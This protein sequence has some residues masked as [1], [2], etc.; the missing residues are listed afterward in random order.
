M[1]KQFLNNYDRARDQYEKLIVSNQ[2]FKQ[3]MEHCFQTEEV[4]VHT[5]RPHLDAW[6][7]L[8]VQRI[9]RYKLLLGEILKNTPDDHSGRSDTVAAVDTI[10]DIAKELD[11]SNARDHMVQV[12]RE[13]ADLIRHEYSSL[14]QPDRLFKKSGLVTVHEEVE[15][16]NMRTSKRQAYLFSDLLVLLDHGNSQSHSILTWWLDRKH[17]DVRPTIL[18]LMFS[19]IIDADADTREMRKLLGTRDGWHIDLN[20]LFDQSNVECNAAI[21]LE[22]FVKG[23]RVKLALQFETEEQREEWQQLLVK[24]MQD[25]Y[26]ISNFRLVGVQRQSFHAGNPHKD[27]FEILEQR[28][29]LQQE[30]SDRARKKIAL[31]EH[32]VHSRKLIEE[33]ERNLSVAQEELKRLQEVIAKSERQLAS[34]NNGFQSM[35]KQLHDVDSDFHRKQTAL[36][37]H[38]DSLLRVLGHEKEALGLTTGE[39][40]DSDIRTPIS[41]P[42]PP[43]QM[44]KT[45]SLSTIKSPHLTSPSRKR[46]NSISSK[47]D[48]QQPN[49][50]FKQH[51]Q[52]KQHQKIQQ[53]TQQMSGEVMKRETLK[54]I[55]NDVQKRGTLQKVEPGDKPSHRQSQIITQLS[56]RSQESTS[57][58]TSTKSKGINFSESLPQLR[59]SSPP[60]LASRSQASIKPITGF[61]QSTP[62]KRKSG[63]PPPPP[64]PRQR[65][66]GSNPISDI[67]TL[68]RVSSVADR[69]KQFQANQEN[70]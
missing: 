60:P 12:T 7:I 36:Q 64:P 45:F 69:I 34:L 51:R 3:F 59:K 44:T 41:P 46:S 18:F 29:L 56:S 33:E 47:V 50:K 57:T 28:L 32:M 15:A 22:S 62:Q 70:K 68:E 30:V 31:E 52:Q 14:V 27:G 16:G 26:R 19:K 61:N 42:D 39:N 2:R 6:L 1:Y 23:Q 17:R 63:P 67:A 48:I 65:P 37:E 11:E 20:P 35:M 9:P 40:I 24:A 38:D 10:S 55:A 66:N 58:S 53:R 49:D 54:M 5:S 4:L 13:I 25:Q 8:P 43:T 21:R